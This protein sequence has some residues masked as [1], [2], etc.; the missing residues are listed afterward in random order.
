MNHRASQRKQQAFNVK[1]SDRRYFNRWDQDTFYFA[2]SSS[3]Q[4]C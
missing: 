1:L 3:K 4:S 2:G